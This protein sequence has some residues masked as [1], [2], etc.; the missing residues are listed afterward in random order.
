VLDGGNCFD[1]L[2]L[3]RE[4]RR[5]TRYYHNCLGQVSVARAFTCYQMTCLLADSPSRNTPTI[6][7]E[8]LST[9]EDENI[10]YRERRHHLGLLLPDLTRLSHFAPVFVSADAEAVFFDLLA[11]T[12]DQIWQFE[13]PAPTV[14][15]GRLF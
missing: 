5:Q 15:Q 6:V 8:P 1:G 14:V 10:P 2:K 3:A 13:Q 9:F 11:D 12:A 4:L 7:L